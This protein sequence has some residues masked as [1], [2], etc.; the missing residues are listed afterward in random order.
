MHGIYVLSSKYKTKYYLNSML[1]TTKEKIMK[2]NIVLYVLYDE[3]NIY[4]LVFSLKIMKDEKKLMKSQYSVAH[5][6]NY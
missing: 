2:L 3:Q 1:G 6:C 5:S 4:L